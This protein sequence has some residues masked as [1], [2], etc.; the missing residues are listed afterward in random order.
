MGPNPCDESSGEPRR[1][2]TPK[3]Q[4]IQNNW[5]VPISTPSSISAISQSQPAHHLPQP[6]PPEIRNAIYTLA[7]GGKTYRLNEHGR[8]FNNRGQHVLALLATCRQI[9]HETHA[10]PFE[11]KTFYLSGAGTLPA[12]LSYPANASRMAMMKKLPWN[13][14]LNSHAHGDLSTE[15][16]IPD[17]LSQADTYFS[18]RSFPL[19]M[20]LRITLYFNFCICGTRGVDKG[21]LH[22]AVDKEVVKVAEEVREKLVEFGKE[23]GV[24][25]V[26]DD[27]RSIDES[28]RWA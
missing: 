26:F 10:M 6:P 19:L 20:N 11:L 28:C 1:A 24:A 25:V 8:A 12:F 7:L 13:V 18:R 22:A 17:A 3:K 21:D 15:T 2:K 14:R 23:E 16:E 5:N 27:G 4:R 9:W